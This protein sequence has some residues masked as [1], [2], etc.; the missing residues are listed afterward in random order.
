VS[1]RPLDAVNAVPQVDRGVYESG[2][3]DKALV[4][5]VRRISDPDPWRVGEDPP[6]SIVERYLT[7]GEYR[8]LIEEHARTSRAFADVIEALRNDEEERDE[9]PISAGSPVVGPGS[10]GSS[11]AAPGAD[12]DP[13]ADPNEPPR[14][15]GKGPPLR[16]V[17]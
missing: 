6:W 8:E 17:R 3:V 14:S 12:P 1:R 10:A 13:A 5:R 2:V 15:P 11:G 4:D 9:G 7:T 16:V